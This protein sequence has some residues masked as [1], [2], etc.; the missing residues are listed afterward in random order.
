M[1][2]F[3]GFISDINN[4]QIDSI[5]QKFNIYFDRFKERGPDYSEVKIKFK[6]KIIQV[7]FVRL[8]IQDLNKKSNKIFYDDNNLI[9]FN[10]E[11]YNH[12]EL[13]KNI[14]KITI[15]LLI[16]IRKFYLN[17]SKKKGEIIVNE[18]EGIFSFVY[19]NLKTEKIFMAEISREQNL[20]I[21]YAIIKDLFFSSEAWFLYSVSD[22]ELDNKSVNFFKFWIH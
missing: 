14:F 7:G 3:I 15:F 8:S 5:S 13:K 19:I 17:Y 21:I 11:I 18:L 1:C 6:S 4:K 22:R 16:L 20:F 12:I 10:G 9:L 2:G